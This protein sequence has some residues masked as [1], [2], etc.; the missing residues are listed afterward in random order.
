MT[1]QEIARK[2][3]A[4]S[5]LMNSAN[6]VAEQRQKVY[7]DFA[8][9]NGLI[10]G[11][12]TSGYGLMPKDSL[13]RTMFDVVNIG[14]V[15]D[16]ARRIAYL[17]DTIGESGLPIPFDEIVVV[18]GQSLA[19]RK[20]LIDRFNGLLP[21]RQEIERLVRSNRDLEDFAAST[22][23]STASRDEIQRIIKRNQQRL[24]KLEEKNP[25]QAIEELRAKLAIERPLTVLK[26]NGVIIGAIAD[27]ERRVA[28][29]E[30]VTHKSK[31][32][33]C[34][35]AKTV[36]GGW[37]HSRGMLSIE[38]CQHDADNDVMDSSCRSAMNFNYYSGPPPPTKSPSQA[39][40]VAR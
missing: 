33:W 25:V 14:E 31:G 21:D 40:G 12:T 20:E 32:F 8:A 29:L 2:I 5:A 37:H 7:L 23:R 27:G 30:P 9:K 35:D 26:S 39:P 18:R 16:A 11:E 24:T 13:K 38:R 28:S 3:A 36:T 34:R 22:S 10:H 19:D 4:A 17:R 6:D 1:L 15:A